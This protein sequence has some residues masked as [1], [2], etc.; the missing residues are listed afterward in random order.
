M[1]I[2]LPISINID[3]R[4]KRKWRFSGKG[5]QLQRGLAQ[6][7]QSNKMLRRGEYMIEFR[8]GWAYIVLN[9]E[10]I[11]CEGFKEL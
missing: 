9:L 10:F 3:V 8:R 5:W 7:R 1:N 11:E 2:I 6:W 4:E